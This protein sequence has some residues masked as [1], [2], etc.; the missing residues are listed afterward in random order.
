MTK[1]EAIETLR[2][3]LEK[4]KRPHY[5]CEDCWYTCPLH[6]E[7]SC[8]EHKPK[9]CDCGADEF[10]AEIGRVLHETS[11]ERRNGDAR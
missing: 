8:N 3:A 4:A 1:D 11:P 2:T 6:P 7:G 5:F 9:V 10:N